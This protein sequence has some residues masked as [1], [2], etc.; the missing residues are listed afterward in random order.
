[1]VN[2]PEDASEGARAALEMQI[3]HQKQ[4]ID[5]NRKEPGDAVIE[6]KE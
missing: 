4:I 5:E 3:E 2:A 6:V 1:M